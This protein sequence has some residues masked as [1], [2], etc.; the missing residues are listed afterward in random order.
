LPPQYRPALEHG[1][2]RQA[3][4]IASRFPVLRRSRY[5][6]ASRVI[7]T[8]AARRCLFMLDIL[9]SIAEFFRYPPSKREW[10]L[11]LGLLLTSFVTVGVLVLVHPPLN[12]L[13]G[14]PLGLVGL[15]L[16]H[17]WNTRARRKG[18]APPAGGWRD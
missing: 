14:I 17:Q 9:R 11:S 5:S 3:L 10:R 8:D 18:K 4:A 1:G 2:Y 12:C 16:S 13:V 15:Y 6:A 7:Q